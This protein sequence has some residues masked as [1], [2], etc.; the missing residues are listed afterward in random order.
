MILRNFFLLSTA[1]LASMANAITYVKEQ[2]PEQTIAI[3]N[4]TTP[5]NDTPQL[6]VPQQTSLVLDRSEL[7]KN[8]ELIHRTFTPALLENNIAAM[9]ILLPLYTEL[10]DHDPHLATWG[11]AMLARQQ[12]DFTQAIR[13]YRQLFALNPKIVA[14]RYQLAQTLFLNNDNIAAK[15]QFEKLRAES[16]SPEFQQLIE[17]Y[18]SALNQRDE[19]YI[20][21]SVNYLNESN[22]N[23]APKSATI[24]QWKG[25]ESE[26]ATGFAY[27]INTHKK[28]SWQN[29]FFSKL[30]LYG[31]GKYYWDNKKYN[32]LNLRLGI[33]IGYQN[34]RNEFSLTPFHEKRWYAGGSTGSNSLKQF[35]QNSGLRLYMSHWLNTNWQISTAFEYGEQRYTSR[36][37]L[38]GNNYLASTSL[39]YLPNSEQYWLF[40]LDYQR[41]NA[42]DKDN[43]FQRKVLR[44]GWGQEWKWGLSTYFT[45]N[46]GRREYQ[47]PDFF[48]I[49]QK[50]NEYYTQLSLWHRNIHFWGITPKLSLSYQKNDSNHP[51]YRYDK[52][53]LFLEMSKRF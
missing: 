21:A 17:K 20:A 13:L 29:G 25:W 49:Q 35:S 44:L 36:K 27:F 53:R 46:Y 42:R 28:W 31:N 8:P 22:V 26:S 9:P 5:L 45:L 24:G 30:E 33:G 7:R 19:W 10:P 39:L 1:L 41:E 14:L 4:P 47:A 3:A 38:N 40:G 23:N 37:Y 51:F 32:E 34:A 2:Q 16:L 18:L 11:K 12:G 52:T 43:A 15:D 50:N 6:G 48:N